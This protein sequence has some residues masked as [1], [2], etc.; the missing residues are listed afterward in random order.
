MLAASDDILRASVLRRPLV[1]IDVRILEKPLFKA[2]AE[3]PLDRGVKLLHGHK[4]A[5][6]RERKALRVVVRLP[7]ALVVA[8]LYG[9]GH[10]LAEVFRK[11]PA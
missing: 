9:K 3:A 2:A 1:W 11:P 5:L 10:R 8:V 4:P 7:A 6:K